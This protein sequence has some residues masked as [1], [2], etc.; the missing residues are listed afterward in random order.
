MI[1]GIDHV[2][3]T[4]RSI[5]ESIRFYVD[6]LGMRENTVDGRTAVHFGQ[7]KIN[8]HPAAG[9]PIL[10]RAAQP[11]PGSADFCLLADRPIEAV[12]VVLASR[13][14]TLEQGPVQREGARGPMQSVYLRDPDGNLVEISSYEPESSLRKGRIS[15]EPGR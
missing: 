1:D 15:G 10:P 8:L 5:A 4:V 2:V 9:A 7:H 6:G 14:L 3:L 13:G 11:G 12:L